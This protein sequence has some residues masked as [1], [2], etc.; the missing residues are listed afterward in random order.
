MFANNDLIDYLEQR[1]AITVLR[2]L[3]HITNPRWGLVKDHAIKKLGAKSL[4]DYSYRRLCKQLVTLKLAN[5]VERDPVK[6]DYHLTRSGHEMARIIEES[7]VRVE[8]WR[9]RVSKD[10]GKPTER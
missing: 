2:A 4:S 1:N 5:S 7:L 6:M 8:K 3:H 10:T 9:R